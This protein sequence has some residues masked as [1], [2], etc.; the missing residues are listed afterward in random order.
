MSIQLFSALF[1][2]ESIR[3]EQCKI[4]FFVFKANKNKSL[5]PAVFFSPSTVGQ[6][7]FDVGPKGQ[8]LKGPTWQKKERWRDH[9]RRLAG[10]NDYLGERGNIQ[11]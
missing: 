1:I 3:I 8:T 10:G 11:P 4:V 2:V 9:P 6:S 5:V 7:V